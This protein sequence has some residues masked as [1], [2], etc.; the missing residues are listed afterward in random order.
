MRIA[1]DIF[2][3]GNKLAPVVS[4]VGP[5]VAPPAPPTQPAD[6]K[7]CIG[8]TKDEEKQEVEGRFLQGLSNR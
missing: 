2:A 6:I 5:T 3:A 7:G 1:E 8:V 4:N